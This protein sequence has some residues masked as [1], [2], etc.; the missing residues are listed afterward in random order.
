MEGVE[1]V[2]EDEEIVGKG[3]SLLNWVMLVTR[4][5]GVIEDAEKEDVLS[6]TSMGI[7]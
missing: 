7:D 1:T 4:V 6:G 3:S 2:S 5:D